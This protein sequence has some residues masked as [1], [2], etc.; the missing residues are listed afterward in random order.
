MA[1]P[2][3]LRS[4]CSGRLAVACLAGMLL[5]VAPA[6]AQTGTVTG[7]VTNSATGL[8][9]ANTTVLITTLNGTSVATAS[10]DASGVY[11]ATGVPP[12][13]LYFAVAGTTGGDFVR[14]FYPD[15]KC[16]GSC[17]VSQIT[18]ATS[19]SVAGGATVP[20]IDFTLDPAARISGMVANAAGGAAINFATVTAYARIGTTIFNVGSASTNASGAYSIGA[21]PGGTYFLLTS[22]SS[23]FRNEIYDN[24]P[25]QVSCSSTTAVNEGTPV[26]VAAGT[27]VTGKDFALDEGGRISGT[28]T[29]ATTGA[30]IANSFVSAY[31][32]VAGFANFAGSATT[33]AAGQYTIQ[34]LAAGAYGVV[35]SQSSNVNYTNEIYNDI[36]C[37][38][39]CSTTTTVESGSLVPVTLGTTTPGINIALSPGGSISGTVTNEATGSPIPNLSVTA[40][41]IVGASTFTRSGS[42]NATGNYTITGLPAGSYG[43]YTSGGSFIHE[44]F[45]NMPCPTSCSSTTAFDAGT[46]VP[47]TVGGTASG[48]NFALQPRAT[49]SIT[50][51]VTDDASGLPIA[52]VGVE[53][54]SVSGTSLSFIGTSTT[55]VSGVYTRT[56]LAIGSYRA[57]T[58]GTHRFR[59]EVFDGIPCL[60]SLCSTSVI[61][62]GTPID[63]TA[64]GPAVAS[65][66]LSRGDGV[67]GTVTN[68]ATGQPAAGVTVSLYQ[69]PSGQFAGSA[70]TND[71]GVFVVHG[72]PNGTYV[73]LTSNSLGL[74]NEIYNNIRCTTS[75]SSST[76]V[77]SGTAITVT[78]AAAFTEGAELV[79]G[80]NF[81]LDVRDQAPA[82]PSSLRIVTTAGTGVFTWTAP[83]LFS[84]GAATSY[85]L[86]AGG[87]PG[88][89][90]IT[91]PIPGTGTSFTVPGVPPGTYYVRLRAVNAFGTGPASNEVLLVVGA[92]GNQLPDAPTNVLPFVSNGLLTLTWTSPSGGGPVTDYVVE[93]GS[94]SGSSN[95]ATLTVARPVFTYS[96]V[97]AGFYFFRVRARNSAG[98][99]AA[100]TEVLLVVGGVAAPPNPPTFSGASVSGST[101]TL[102]WQAPQGGTPATSYIVEAG[103]ATGLANLAVANVGN[104]LTQSFA[105]V[106]PGT[107]YIRIRAMNAQGVSVVSTERVITVS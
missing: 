98:V 52:G 72:V 53:I 70:S 68:A 16:Y 46:R 49:G 38:I 105:G 31:I 95:I 40:V 37:P 5:S 42:T 27:T 33:N 62:T 81:A 47:V 93:V 43:L 55:N 107:Y 60:S 97:P 48:R 88:T 24:M 84:N 6:A 102:S 104:V 61:S 83:S 44:I 78:G 77:A 66:A 79:S 101:V 13:A 25:C 18:D 86:E 56:D 54:W 76:A 74:Y 36:L 45:D 96:P 58:S 87:S 69:R 35:T 67:T 30:P 8:P 14:E 41:V 28:M 59:N 65:F 75:C 82:A 20:G 9:I 89:T 91:L 106:P 92:G 15:V 63:V 94:A 51:L 32:K 7:T 85:L 80:I 11:T 1:P 50:G 103:S 4:L 26:V 71:R 29:D 34:G 3:L 23:G 99:G 17:F 57:D 21:L 64:P 2:Q 39:G 100:S 73:A 22:N 12:G 90:F 19:F 10:T